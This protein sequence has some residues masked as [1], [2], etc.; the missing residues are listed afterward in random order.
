MRKHLDI[1]GL[2][3]VRYSRCRYTGVIHVGDGE[4]PVQ[5]GIV[6]AN[7][8][9]GFDRDDPVTDRANTDARGAPLCEW[10]APLPTPRE[11]DPI[12]PA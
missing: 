5:C 10:P 12:H 9:D 7:D 6:R 8:I 4:L 1:V 2:R 11:H 3:G